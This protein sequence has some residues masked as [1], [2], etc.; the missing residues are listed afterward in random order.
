MTNCCLRCR[1]KNRS[2]FRLASFVFHVTTAR[3]QGQG[4]S[5]WVHSFNRHETRIPATRNFPSAGLASRLILPVPHGSSLRSCG[6]SGYEYCGPRS[7]AGLVHEPASLELGFVGQGAGLAA[8]KLASKIHRLPFLSPG[9][10]PRLLQIS[11]EFRAPFIPL[12]VGGRRFRVR[13]QRSNFRR[14]AAYRAVW[15]RKEKAETLCR[16]GWPAP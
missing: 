1:D 11:Q 16:P 6:R 4:S 13:R 7:M 14:N 10:C 15:N 9:F 5:V 12:H 3:L 2:R 8:R